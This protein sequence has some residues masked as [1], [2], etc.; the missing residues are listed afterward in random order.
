MP[1]S[2]LGRHLAHPA[3]LE[4]RRPATN[5]LLKN[6]VAGQLESESTVEFPG[7]S[8]WRD[9]SK[10][11]FQQP[12]KEEP[13]VR[14]YL[15]MVTLFGTIGCTAE[16]N[17]T[18][19]QAKEGPTESTKVE[20]V[21]IPYDASRPKYIVVVSTPFGIGTDA[22]GASPVPG[23]PRA[24]GLPLIGGNPA[25]DAYNPLPPGMSPRA[26]TGLPAQLASALG[27]VG[28]VVIVDYDFY[29][30]NVNNP[31]KLVRKGE[32]GPFVI[33]GTVTEFTEVAEAD[34]KNKQA[35]VG[36]AGAMA[37]IA[38]AV[39]HSTAA[40][41]AGAG[42]TAANPTYQA[43]NAKRTG[44]VSLDLQIVDPTSGRIEGTAVASGNF[45]AESA[46]SG[47][48]VFGIGGGE[49][50]FAQSALGQATRAAMNDAIKQIWE[51]LGSAQPPDLSAPSDSRK[52]KG[53]NNEKPAASQGKIDPQ[54]AQAFTI[55]SATFSEG[56]MPGG[57]SESCLLHLSV[58]NNTDQI[59][60]ANVNYFAFD[61]AD[62]AIGISACGGNNIKPHSEASCSAPFLDTRQASAPLADCSEVTR[63]DIRTIPGARYLGASG[64]CLR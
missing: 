49:A 17:K 55:N 62:H 10:I 35:S 52:S 54:F 50:A 14:R 20:L 51:R 31:S 44:S 33:K 25:P 12:A 37:T 47:L 16:V 34:V 19:T 26:A 61:S 27:N 29:R 42:L 6:S 56:V 63:I 15:L 57:R 32:I 46:T 36:W 39:A 64:Q 40:T 11:V 48:S 9:P 23:A 13:I 59:C 21:K 30:A 5:R 45:T 3:S 22:R 28:N 24:R 18:G 4:S 43:T 41:A 60:S 7:K 38:G 1:L 58:S 8:S 2:T 53:R